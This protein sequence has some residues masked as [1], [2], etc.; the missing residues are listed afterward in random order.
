MKVLTVVTHPRTNSLTFAVAEQFVQGL[1]DAGHETEVLD[2]YRNGFDPV[3]READEPDWLDRKPYSPEVEAEI[4]RMER[5]DALAYIFPIWWYNVPAMLRGYIE[6]VWNYGYAYGTTK[7]PHKKALWIG[8]AAATVDDFQ[9][10]DY[11][12]M[13]DQQLNMGIANYS[14]IADS[15]LDIL[16]DTLS[17]DREYMAALLK[18]AYKLGLH[19]GD[20]QPARSDSDSDR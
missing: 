16:Y 6:R 14:G 20:S 8:L 10:R 11:D 13:M 15:K 9:K 17:S 3:L 12:K 18:H 4:E 5:H 7:L 2:L 1:Q 19:Y